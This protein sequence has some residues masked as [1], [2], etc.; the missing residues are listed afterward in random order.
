M[1]TRTPRLDEDR[2]AYYRQ[3]FADFFDGDFKLGMGTE[4]I[5]DTLY[6]S[7]AGGDWLDLGSGP[8]TL[9]WSIAL[10]ETIRSI[11]SVDAAEEALAVLREANNGS[12]VPRAYQQVLQRYGREPGHLHEMK[13]R[14]AGYHA[15]DAMAAWPAEFDGQRFDL[16]TEF[17]LFGLSPDA[18]R[19]RRCFPSVHDHL[20]P[21]GVAVGAD[22]IRSAEYVAE[23]GHDNTY[24]TE[25][26]VSS[27][28]KEAG[29]TPTRHR[30]CPIEGDALYD[31]LIV[32]TAERTP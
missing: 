19:Y 31:A 10:P 28:I 12:R 25:A 17:G 15:F 21:G 14:M 24:L 7:E 6:A 26:L 23:E 16:V 11:R 18:E 2:L 9:F 8:C 1:T 3:Y 27:A 22:W 29:L 32:W 30:L 5:L 4:D 20:R 13:S